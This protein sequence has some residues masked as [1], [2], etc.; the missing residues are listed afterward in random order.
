MNDEPADGLHTHIGASTKHDELLI[1]A[2]QSTG[3]GSDQD[4][5]VRGVDAET[6]TEQWQIQLEE[7]FV[8]GLVASDDRLFV[9]QTF[10]IKT[11]RLST[12]EFLEEHDI[13]IGF[14][15]AGHADD[16]LYVPGDRMQ[17]LT[18]P[19]ATEYWGVDTDHELNT[20]PG[21]GDSGVYVGTEAGFVLGYDRETGE[22]LWEARVDGS[23]E[24][25][26][27][28]AEGCVWIANERGEFTA[29]IEET[30]E[31]VYNEDVEP[32]F[33]FAITDGILKDSE[34]E[35]AFEITGT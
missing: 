25:R 28:V 6:G 32:G 21:L 27:I 17:A 7:S 26:P 23:I 5:I 18:L 34:R 15:R 3:S 16:R 1:Y 19:S 14:S 11:Y 29:F 4:P 24:H 13:P 9:Q 12:R 33:E 30:G 10:S 31:R 35:S 20:T 2:S 8:N 22:Q